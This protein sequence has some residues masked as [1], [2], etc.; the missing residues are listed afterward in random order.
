MLPR[1]KSYRHSMIWILEDILKFV[2]GKLLKTIVITSWTNLERFMWHVHKSDLA[3]P[4]HCFWRECRYIAG[5]LLKHLVYW[6]KSQIYN[7][8]I[9]TYERIKPNAAL[10]IWWKKNRKNWFRAPLKSIKLRHFRKQVANYDLI[11]RMYRKKLL[12]NL[13]HHFFTKKGE[14]LVFLIILGFH[15]TLHHNHKFPTFFHLKELCHEIQ[16][17]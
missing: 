12:I 11:F 15:A 1:V 6:G 13:L 5:L 10:K 4:S 9:L 8:P 3:P 16:P 14:M 17:D 7:V 2:M